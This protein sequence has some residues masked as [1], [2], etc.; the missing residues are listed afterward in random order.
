MFLVLFQFLVCTLQSSLKCKTWTLLYKPILLF[1]NCSI[2]AGASDVRNVLE[3]I[4]NVVAEC[5]RKINEHQDIVR[6][7]ND[8]T[9]CHLNLQ[10]VSSHIGREVFDT[11]YSSIGQLLSL[12]RA[13]LPDVGSSAEHVIGSAEPKGTVKYCF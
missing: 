5:G 1:F 4:A 11:M 7:V 8:L 9:A 13:D 12:A 3:R 6:A 10:R 2:M